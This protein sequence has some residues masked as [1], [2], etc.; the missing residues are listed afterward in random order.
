MIS[1]L[2]FIA[3]IAILIIMY[4]GG[5]LGWCLSKLRLLVPVIFFIVCLFLDGHPDWLIT[6]ILNFKIPFTKDTFVVDVILILMILY[7]V[8]MFFHDI[9]API[10]EKVQDI[11]LRKQER[12][13][14]LIQKQAEQEAINNA[15]LENHEHKKRE[16]V[17]F[18]IIPDMEKEY[19]Y[20]K[21]Q[22]EN[23]KELALFEKDW[24]DYIYE[25]YRRLTLNKTDTYF[26][27]DWYRDND[28]WKQRTYNKEFL[29]KER[30]QRTKQA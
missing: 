11:R 7:A 2:I 29:A 13:E 12:K 16:K 26:F 6:K 15:I 5:V 19:Y 4:F 14:M 24:K 17:V 30:A 25:A 22:C 20:F 10:I 28:M 23:E 8:I 18:S 3:F 1:L 9:F 21:N 27:E